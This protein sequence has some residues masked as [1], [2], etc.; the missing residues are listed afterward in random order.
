MRPRCS[1]GTS[2]EPIPVIH[3]FDRRGT[4]KRG[5]PAHRVKR[6][7]AG[8][9]CSRALDPRAGHDTEVAAQTDT[10]PAHRSV[11][12]EYRGVAL[13]PAFTGSGRSPDLRRRRRSGRRPACPPRG[14]SGP[15]ADGTACIAAD[16]RDIAAAGAMDVARLAARHLRAWA[17]AFR[18]AGPLASTPAWPVARNARRST[19]GSACRRRR[20]DWRHNVARARRPAGP[21]PDAAR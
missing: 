18:A 16:Q 19:A 3:A 11:S 2:F 20:R 17:P 9:T 4:A 12:T 7:V 6:P 10:Q 1:S 5:W 13:R 14:A 15:A 21:I 8:S